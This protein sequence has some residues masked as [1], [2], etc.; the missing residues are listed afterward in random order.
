MERRRAAAEASSGGS[1]ACEFRDGRLRGRSRRERRCGCLRVRRQQQVLHRSARF[2]DRRSIWNPPCCNAWRGMHPQPSEP[3]TVSPST[4]S[5]TFVWPIV[6]SAALTFLRSHATSF[7]GCRDKPFTFGRQSLQ[8][9]STELKVSSG[10][11]Q[12]QRHLHCGGM[13]MQGR[14]SD[15]HRSRSHAPGKQQLMPSA[16]RARMEG[17]GALHECF[18]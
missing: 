8:M 16:S 3:S 1:I 12:L 4:S 13:K 2:H 14:S 18:R 15:M 9:R 10:G 11:E 5:W 17:S 6:S 7:Q